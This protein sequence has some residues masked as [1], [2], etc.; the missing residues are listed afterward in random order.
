[1]ISDLYRRIYINDSC[2]IGLA[3]TGF[4]VGTSQSSLV[5]V[6]SSLG[7]RRRMIVQNRSTKSI[8][9]GQTGV[10]TGS[11]LEIRG[12]VSMSLDI[13][14]DVGLFAIAATTGNDV[15]VFELA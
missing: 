6:G 5:A 14:P 15:R 1:M 13:G 3:S 2:N 12:G 10:T 7:G 4:T 8:F 11:G 9:V